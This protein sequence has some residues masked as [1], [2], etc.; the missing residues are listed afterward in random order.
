[1]LR[2]K[3]GR[4][5]VHPF[6]RERNRGLL[7]WPA[8][9][10]AGR[11]AVERRQR[12]R[13]GCISASA[14]NGHNGAVR[15]SHYRVVVA[16]E[17]R[18]VV[19]E[20][21]VGD[22][23]GNE[24]FP[25]KVVVCLDGFLAQVSAGHDERVHAAGFCRG[26]QQMLKR[27][28]GK[29]NTEFGKVVCDGQREREG[30]GG[31]AALANST[32][33]Q[34]HNGTNTAGQ[35]AALNVVDMAQAFSVGKVA[36]HNGK[37]FVAAAF[38]AAK[39]GYRL[40]VGGVACQVKSAQ[41]LDSDDTAV[42]QQLNTAVD[43]GVAVLARGADDRRRG[44]FARLIA[45]ARLVPCNMRPAIKAGIGLRVKTPV[46]WVGILRGALG[47]HGKTIH[48][49][50]RSVIRQRSDDGK[51]RAAVGAV[52]KGVVIASVGGIEQLAQAI[53]AGGDIGRD[54]RRVR[55]LVLRC[56]DAKTL[57]TGGI[58]TVG[59]QV[60]S[61]DMLYAGCRRRMLGKRGNKSIER[62]GR[63]MRLDVHAVARIEHPQ[64]QMPC[65]MASRYTNGRM[66]TPCTMPVT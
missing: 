34:Q 52:D 23:G 1:M 48:R 46:E 54:E 49:R 61:L 36:Y 20:Q 59:C 40:L 27:G 60:H 55:G 35:Q 44:G 41:T 5:A 37:R 19:T 30:V 31:T 17:D 63:G 39:L 65:A 21:R 16:R 2:H 56:Y 42:G 8:G 22:A 64:P 11:S 50:G 66:P 12:Q 57:F 4:L 43:N 6:T 14:A 9:E 38:A 18:A 29:H 62:I 25:G 53:V 7:L 58:P 13:L 32:S 26:K 33:A 15:L 47:T 45:H 51:A 24:V 28:V 3:T 10:H